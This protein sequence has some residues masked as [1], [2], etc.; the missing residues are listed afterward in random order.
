LALLFE[1]F[2]L[3]LGE[4][5]DVRLD[6]DLLLSLLLLENRLDLLDLGVEGIK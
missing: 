4:D 3:K 5:L 2:L 1:K 6:E